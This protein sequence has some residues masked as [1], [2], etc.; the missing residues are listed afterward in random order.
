MVSTVECDG[1]RVKHTLD[2]RRNL[3][4]TGDAPEPLDVDLDMVGAGVG[5][6]SKCCLGIGHWALIT[7]GIGIEKLEL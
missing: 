7:W 6:A 5:A 4:M 1:S 3:A 2:S